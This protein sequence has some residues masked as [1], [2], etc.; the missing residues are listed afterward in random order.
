[1]HFAVPCALGDFQVP[2]WSCCAHRPLKSN[3]H[4]A[5][6]AQ[7]RIRVWTVLVASRL[8]WHVVQVVAVV[9]EMHNVSSCGISGQNGCIAFPEPAIKAPKLVWVTR[10]S[11]LSFVTIIIVGFRNAS[12]LLHQFLMSISNLLGAGAVFTSG[13][14]ASPFSKLV[15]PCRD[16]G[17]L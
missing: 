11:L 9:C 12:D 14:T 8:S 15:L 16:K 5:S 6:R 2:R 10:I 13:N 7:V 1:V 3:Q 4:R 17:M